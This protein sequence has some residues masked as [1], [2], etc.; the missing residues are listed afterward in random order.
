MRAYAVMKANVDAVLKA[1]GITREDLSKYCRREVSWASKILNDPERWFPMPY[2]D[3]ISDFLGLLPYQLLQPGISAVTERRKTSD[4]RSG[5]DRRLSAM[6][7]HVRES[8]S[9]T[10]AN[11][12]AADVADVIRWR[13]LT[14]ESRA[15]VRETMQAV[16]R[17]EQQGARRRRARP[18]AEMVVGAATPPVGHAT[19]RKGSGAKR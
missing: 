3:R 18:S 1:R 16:E 5:R 7:H 15:A 2:W 19:E 12:S 4:R 8:V 10:I 6:S 14:E 11:L 9:S 13:T 17:S